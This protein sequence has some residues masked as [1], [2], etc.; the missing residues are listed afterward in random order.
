MTDQ[1]L[2]RDPVDKM[3]DLRPGAV[4]VALGSGD[5]IVFRNGRGPTISERWFGGYKSFVEVD[6]SAKTFDEA[7]KL[8][9]SKAT[10]DFDATVTVRYQVRESNV[11]SI[12]S[13]GVKDGRNAIWP[14]LL[15]KLQ[16]A[17]RQ[18]DGLNV[19]QGNE[20]AVAAAQSFC[21]AYNS[22]AERGIE[23]LSIIVNVNLTSE[24]RTLLKQVELED[25]QQKSLQSEQ[26]IAL[27][28]V[29]N[30]QEVDKAKREEN[31]AIMNGGLQNM[32]AQLMI[33]NPK[34]LADIVDNLAKMKQGQHSDRMELFR[35][36]LAGGQIEAHHIPK[37]VKEE[38]LRKVL[39][40]KEE[41][42]GLLGANLTVADASMEIAEKKSNE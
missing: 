34:A 9:S 18:A 26:K 4:V 7:T 11:T 20:S 36:L 6:L 39:M 41:D 21:M 22:Q 13:R 15:A 27:Q 29:K 31:F 17:T 14:D 10:I 35:E 16:L 42:I 32:F 33:D 12:I 38:F 23:I 24:A 25:F 8:P 28:K 2:Y 1:I 40:Q 19:N 3:P 30:S 37:E 5:P